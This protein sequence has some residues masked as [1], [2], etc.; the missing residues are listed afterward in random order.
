MMACQNQDNSI[1][2]PA[3]SVIKTQNGPSKPK[4]RFVYCFQSAMI[5]G[6]F[7][8]FVAALRAGDLDLSL[9]FRDTDSR[10]ALAAA[11]KFMRIPLF[12]ALFGDPEKAFYLIDLFQKPQPFPGAFHMIPGKGAVNRVDQSDQPQ[13]IEES[14]SC[15]QG[16]DPETSLHK[17]CKFI[18]QIF[19]KVFHNDPSFLV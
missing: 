19:P 1:H 6:S 8:K 15:D 16:Q 3:N 4:G 17:C 10:T 9:A 13:C 2:F 12:P 5:S 11:E 14:F 18:L 7:N